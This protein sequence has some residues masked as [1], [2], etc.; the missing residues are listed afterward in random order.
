LKSSLC[1]LVSGVSASE[2]IAELPK[3]SRKERRQVAVA[4]FELEEDADLLRDCDR[5]A[6][7]R[8]RMLDMMEEEDGKASPR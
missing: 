4:I 6:D 5:R 8:F 1:N 7:E 3:L 2:I